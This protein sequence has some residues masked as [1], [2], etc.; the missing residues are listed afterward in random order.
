M[1]ESIDNRTR[2]EERNVDPDSA[3]VTQEVAEF[4]QDLFDNQKFSPINCCW[5]Q[6]SYFPGASWC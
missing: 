1:P 6:I 4:L 3:P 5:L 2:C